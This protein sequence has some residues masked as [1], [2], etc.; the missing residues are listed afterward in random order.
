L[1]NGLRRT[2]HQF[3]Y[4]GQ[5]LSTPQFFNQRLTEIKTINDVKAREEAL[6]DFI[7]EARELTLAMP[8]I[9]AESGR[10]T[11]YG[12]GTSVLDYERYKQFKG[13]FA[14]VEDYK[15]FA[16]DVIARGGGS[17][18]L[19]IK[20]ADWKYSS[21]SIMGAYAGLLQVQVKE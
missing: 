16:E 19:G 18:G 6:G 15:A 17:S 21:K 8:S 1:F 20:L 3:Y 13:K 10:I 11:R 9:G 12:I 5:T 14:S 4:K 2:S 7:K